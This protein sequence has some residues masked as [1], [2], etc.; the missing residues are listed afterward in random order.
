M[1][2]G[3]GK[4]IMIAVCLKVLLAELGHHFQKVICGAGQVQKSNMHGGR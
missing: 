1:G 2:R 3:D 4:N